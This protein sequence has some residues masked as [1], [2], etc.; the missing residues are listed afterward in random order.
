MKLNVMRHGYGVFV[1]LFNI[2]YG[3]GNLCIL[4]TNS[5]L[6]NINIYNHYH[7]YVAYSTDPIYRGKI[8]CKNNDIIHVN[9]VI[10][11]FNMSVYDFYFI[12]FPFCHA[13]NDFIDYYDI[14]LMVLIL[15]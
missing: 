5:L 2:F 11:D 3:F 4:D 12:N 8:V 6:C 14:I 13:L 15:N 7:I 9:G 10:L 1:N